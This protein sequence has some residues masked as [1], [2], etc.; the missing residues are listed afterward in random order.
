MVLRCST[1]RVG[2]TRVQT[3]TATSEE[4]RICADRLRSSG[5]LMGLKLSHFLH[6]KGI[7]FVVFE[8]RSRE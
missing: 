5:E 3:T 4:K 6:P 8:S 7:E 1:E 2:N